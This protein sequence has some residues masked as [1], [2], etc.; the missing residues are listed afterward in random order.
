MRIHHSYDEFVCMDE[1][2]SESMPSMD[3]RGSSNRG[4]DGR[5]LDLSSEKEQENRGQRAA[6][7]SFPYT[8][9]EWPPGSETV[10][11]LTS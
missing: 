10:F 7:L 6:S 9:E 4:S 5:S 3:H 11:P 8:E 2:R 1:M